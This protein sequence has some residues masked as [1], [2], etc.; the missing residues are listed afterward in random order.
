MNCGVHNWNFIG[1]FYMFKRIIVG[2]SALILSMSMC[3]F[4]ANAASEMPYQVTYTYNGCR[5]I[6]NPNNMTYD[7]KQ[8]V[9]NEDGYLNVKLALESDKYGLIV[10]DIYNLWG[11]F[12]EIGFKGD[13][14]LL[15]VKPVDEGTEDYPITSKV[16]NR[17]VRDNGYTYLNVSYRDMQFT[18]NLGY[19][20]DAKSGNYIAEKGFVFADFNIYYDNDDSSVKSSDFEILIGDTPYTINLDN[21]CSKQYDRY[22]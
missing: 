7:I 22:L 1:V 17:K 11:N 12:I 13:T 2:V 8:T 6:Y 14:D 10:G 9:T 18:H 19:D 16:A 5:Y 21:V 3:S 15:T 20:N 4:I